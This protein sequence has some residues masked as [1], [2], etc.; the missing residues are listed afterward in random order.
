[1]MGSTKYI[2]DDK[3]LA[4]LEKFYTSG[5]AENHFKTVKNQLSQSQRNLLIERMLFFS[6]ILPDELSQLDKVYLIY[7]VITQTVSYDTDKTNN[8]RYSYLQVLK[9]KK[10]VCMGI[11]EMFQILCVACNIPCKLVIGFCGTA[12]EEGEATYH[13][14]N[15][16]C[17]P[18][19]NGN[20]H[21]YMADPTWDLSENDHSWQYF[22]KDDSYFISHEHFWLK[23]VYERCP[24]TITDIPKFPKEGV[25]YLCRVFQ[26]VT[27]CL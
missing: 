25:D 26:K 18:D 16:V 17:L 4:E 12:N 14:W 11:A 21:W 8:D 13:A 10:A 15:Q 9:E 20:K 2:L 7:H 3:V 23:N 1:M 5:Y 6:K 22:L 27:Q 24:Q 19:K